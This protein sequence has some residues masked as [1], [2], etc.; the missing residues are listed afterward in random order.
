MTK[1]P[2]TKEQRAEAVDVVRTLC[3]VAGDEDQVLDVIEGYAQMVGDDRATAGLVAALIVTY[4]SCM[5]QPVPLDP[6]TDP[7]PVNVPQ[8]E[9][10]TR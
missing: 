6:D 7:V 8:P 9:G 10:A 2:F 3:L 4:G 1:P 5:T